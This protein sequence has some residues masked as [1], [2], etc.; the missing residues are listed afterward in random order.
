MTQYFNN[1]AMS[2]DLMF[3]YDDYV[4]EC[5]KEGKEPMTFQQWYDSME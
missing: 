2:V 5:E 4:E 3:Y 1:F